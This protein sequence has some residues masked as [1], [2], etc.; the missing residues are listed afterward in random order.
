MEAARAAR[1]FPLILERLAD[2][3]VH[4]TAVRLLASHLTADNHRAVLD[5]A[6]HKSKREIEHVI[7]CRH[8]QPDV[9]ASVRKLPTSASARPLVETPPADIA[10]TAKG[11]ATQPTFAPCPAARPPMISSLAPGR[12]K[13][14]FTVPKETYDKLRRVQDLMRHRIPNGDPAAIFDRALTALLSELERAK[15]ATA[16]R[17]RADRPTTTSSRHVPAA[18]KRA[19]WA[20][21]GGRCAFIG[22]NGRC[23]ETGLLEFHHVTPYAAGGL[24]SVENLQLRCRAHNA[25]EAEKHLG[26][27]GPLFVRERCSAGWTTAELVPERAAKRL[28]LGDAPGGI[29]ALPDSDTRSRVTFGIAARLTAVLYVTSRMRVGTEDHRHTVAPDR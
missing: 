6:R 7:A 11:T 15:L 20:R 18:V 23:R 9:P 1:R 8:P 5:A 4:L 10:P 25:Y 3:S 24:T 19:V 29:R 28:C 12:Y 26:A 13:V 17:P 22:T 27:E 16:G 2:G 21:D 14:Q